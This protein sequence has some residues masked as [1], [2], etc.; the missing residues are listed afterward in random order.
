MAHFILY[1]TEDGNSKIN[2]TL[3]NGTIWLTQLQIAELFQT[4]QQTISQQIK[5]ILED[6]EL[7]EKV[8]INYQFTATNQ[9]E[10]EDELTKGKVAY[11]N[12]DMIL[13]IG[14]RVQSPRG[15]QFRKYASTTLKEYFIKGFAMDDERFK[16][17]GE[18]NYFKGLLERIRDIHLSEKVFYRQLLDLFATS[19]DY[20]KDSGEAKRFFATVRNKLH[21][22]I[23]QQTTTESGDNQGVKLVKGELPTYSDSKRHL[24]EKELSSFNQLVS[25][26]LG[27]AEKKAKQECTM[28]MK[29][30]NYHIEQLLSKIDDNIEIGEKLFGE[31]I[32]IKD[33]TEQTNDTEY[34]LNQVENDCL[35]EL[36]KIENIV[37]NR[38]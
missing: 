20:N 17:L 9:G 2:L 31:S 23:Y 13:A 28:R 22:P 26:C 27:F 25:E 36:K 35:G 15:I 33:E 19:V 21:F 38:K 12:L 29:D 34:T 7:D 16:H 6:E 4:T 1:H 14:Y 11:Y 5:N 8:V 30:W 18:D 3:K 37:K 32:E 10:I 24:T